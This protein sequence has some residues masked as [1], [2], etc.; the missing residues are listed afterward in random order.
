M[1]RF[2][3]TATIPTYQYS[4]LM[5]EIEVEA[6]TFEEAQVIAMQRLESL[7]AMYGERPLNKKID[8]GVKVECFTGGYLWFNK[9]THTY[10]NDAGEVYLSGS[11]YAHQDDKPF[12]VEKI[13][14]AMAKRDGTNATDLRAMWGMKRDISAG[15]G[16]ALHAAVELAQKY[17]EVHTHPVLK[18]AVDGFLGA[19]KGEVAEL[20]I[21]V[22][23]HEA[24]RCGQIDRLLIIDANKKLCRVQ[25]VK[26]D[27]DLKKNMPA[28]K[29]QL[30]FY[31]EIMEKAGWACQPPEI[32]HYNG[33]WTTVPLS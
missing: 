21:F 7:W 8:K 27:A 19:H 9:D 32:L 15:F 1:Q 3:I 25:D 31:T 14:E 2:K 4:N 26:T 18:S 13:S 10:T 22:A 29:K 12:D 6:D 16:T 24:K 23:D 11:V 33:V 28:Y 20:E 17:D 30:T 5:P